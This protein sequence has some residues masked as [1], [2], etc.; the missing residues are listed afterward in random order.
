MCSI[1]GNSVTFVLAK[2]DVSSLH[3]LLL[4]WNIITSSFNTICMH[5]LLCLV[6]VSFVLSHNPKK[7]STKARIQFH[8]ICS[9]SSKLSTYRS[10]DKMRVIWWNCTLAGSCTSPVSSITYK[11]HPF[12][13]ILVWLFSLSY[14]L[15]QFLIP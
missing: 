3:Y 14:L 1:Y 6:W 10:S 5:N 4:L 7:N 13:F 8:Y 12:I 15:L 2:F 9:S 11:N